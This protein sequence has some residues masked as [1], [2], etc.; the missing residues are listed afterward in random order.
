MGQ[1]AHFL[2]LNRT[3][4]AGLRGQLPSARFS[5]ALSLRA[6][7]NTR[8]IGKGAN[9][10]DGISYGGLVG[11]ALWRKVGTQGL[12]PEIKALQPLC[13]FKQDQEYTA[14]RQEVVMAIV[15]FVLASKV[16]G[17]EFNLG[18][19]KRGVVDDKILDF[20]AVCGRVEGVP[21]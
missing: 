19:L 20:D 13:Q 15:V 4:E 16:P 17:G 12:E 2:I 18:A 5:T 14:V 3:F 1:A 11:L 7:R 9:N 6:L 10:N 8:I 21:F